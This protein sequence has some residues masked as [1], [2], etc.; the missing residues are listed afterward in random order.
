[1]GSSDAL[2]SGHP[3]I[4]GAPASP[5]G[6]SPSVPTTALPEV[7]VPAARGSNAHTIAQLAA[8]HVKLSGQKV[9]VRGQVTK[10][11]AGV[12]GHTFFHLRDGKPSDQPAT[13]LVVTSNSTPERGQV[14]SFEGT[15]RSDV[16]IGIGYSYP[17][18]LE[19][20]VLVAE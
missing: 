16:D 11:T 17:I 6:S 19:N 3:D 20:A 8:E 15:L 1:V 7:V 12:Q 4:N 13:D 14:A 10:V 18:L 9:R 5:H 2:P